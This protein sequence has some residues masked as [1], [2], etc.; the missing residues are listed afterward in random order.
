DDLAV[1]RAGERA[2]AGQVEVAV[3]GQVED[4]VEV[5]RLVG[6]RVVQDQ[7]VGVVQGVGQD[8][9]DLGRVTG[10]AGRA[11]RGPGGVALV[12]VRADQRELHAHGAGTEDRLV[13]P[14]VVAEADDPAVQGVRPV[15]DGDGVVDGTD[16]GLV[17]GE[18]A[19]GDPVGV[20]ADG[21]AEV[22]AGG[23]GDRRAVEL[24]VIGQRLEAE[25]HV[26]RLAIP[27]RPPDVLDG[28]AVGDDL[29]AHAAVVAE[30]VPVYGQVM[31]GVLI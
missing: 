1:G 12:A 19:V 20:P 24:D 2:L 7:L 9:L 4:R 16:S 15:V 18:L 29:H 22:H 3:V 10:A 30:R 31:A 5:L 11:A 26:G 25:H 8:D 23:R 13:G 27:A 17:Q 21:L 14:D 28:R 6:G